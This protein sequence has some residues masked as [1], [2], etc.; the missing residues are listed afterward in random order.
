MKYRLI[1]ALAISLLLSACSQSES[2]GEND[3]VR[4]LNTYDILFTIVEQTDGATLVLKEEQGRPPMVWIR[5]PGLGDLF[6]TMKDYPGDEG[7]Y[8]FVIENNPVPVRIEGM[9]LILKDRSGNDH[10][11]QFD[12]ER[13]LFS[14]Q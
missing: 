9:Q 12:A 14:V 11:L 5:R 2:E 4:L 6:F 10:V 3:L 7:V 13:R 1:S 8:E